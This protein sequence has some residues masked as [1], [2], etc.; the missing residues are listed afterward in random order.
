[1]RK[2]PGLRQFIQRLFDFNVDTILSCTRALK[3]T[4]AYN[5]CFSP[6]QRTQ[7]AVESEALV[8]KDVTWL[9][10]SFQAF[11]GFNVELT[12]AGETFVDLLSRTIL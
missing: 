6:L 3:R 8:A 5:G 4:Q 11:N 10:V 9:V 2:C 7:S 1:M 12:R